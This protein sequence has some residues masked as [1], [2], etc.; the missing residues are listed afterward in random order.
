MNED[1]EKGELL[2]LPA[3]RADW[4]K[5]A[6]YAGLTESVK[7]IAKKFNAVFAEQKLMAETERA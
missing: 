5:E 7:V 1:T 2:K 4:G 6:V 3:C